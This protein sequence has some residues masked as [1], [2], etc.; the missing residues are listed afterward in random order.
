MNNSSI[1]QKPS[2]VYLLLHRTQNNNDK[3]I[4]NIES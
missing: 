1:C 4:E 2:I 3:I